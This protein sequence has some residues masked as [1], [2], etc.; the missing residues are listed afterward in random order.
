[1][2]PNWFDELPVGITVCD[3]Q[4]IIISMNARA[5]LIFKKSGERELI[6]KNMPGKVILEKPLDKKRI[7]AII[8]PRGII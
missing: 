7:K 4:G 6:G 1:M 2:Q 5:A 8:P 3:T